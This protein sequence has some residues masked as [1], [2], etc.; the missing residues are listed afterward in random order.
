M[1]CVKALLVADL[2]IAYGITY[3]LAMA[4]LPATRPTE[5]SEEAL[6]RLAENL[7]AGLSAAEMARRKYPSD[8]VARQRFR[9]KLEAHVL[10]DQRVAQSA[11]AHAQLDLLAGLGPAARALVA[12]AGRGRPDAIKLLF[13]ATGFHNP[14]VQH[15]HSGE[16][17]IK[18]D[19][20]RPRFE[21]DGEP[22]V[23]ATVVD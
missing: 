12:R 16:I 18:L 14:R 19:V 23:D 20:P 21:Q 3:N 22:I 7:N 10:M 17:K 11:W 15:Q 2:F 4:N 5:L 8:R 9:R 1:T 6:Y 13:E